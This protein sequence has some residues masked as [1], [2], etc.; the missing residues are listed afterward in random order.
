MTANCRLSV[1]LPYTD[2][3][4]AAWRP[5]ETHEAIGDLVGTHSNRKIDSKIATQNRKDL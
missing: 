3:L 5:D 4:E 1:M 2:K